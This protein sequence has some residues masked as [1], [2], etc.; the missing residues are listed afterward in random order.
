MAM[1]VS[2]VKRGLVLLGFLLCSCG[3]KQPNS[4]L[5]EPMDWLNN[6]Q[7]LPGADSALVLDPA[8][9]PDT[10]SVQKPVWSTYWYPASQNGTARKPAQWELSP[11]E[12]YDAAVGDSSKKATNWEM[13]QSARFKNV[14]WAGHCNGVAAA[15]TMVDEP[16]KEVWYNN[17]KFT[18]DDV[19]ALMV[20]AF[21]AGGQVIGGRCNLSTMRLDSNGRPIDKECRDTN[22]ASL[23]IALTNYLGRFRKPLI[24]DMDA[25]YPVWNYV[26]TSYQVKMKQN[27]TARDVNWWLSGQDITTYSINPLATSFVYYQME[28]VYNNGSNKIYEYILE[29]SD[30]VNSQTT[31]TTIIGGE[32]FRK[33]LTD[34]PDFLWRHTGPRVENPY[35]NLDVIYNIYNKSI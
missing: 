34:H 19:K 33:A 14:Q 25:N 18:P 30:A 31:G 10:G 5:K 27:L 22:P 15:G 35:L 13:Q 2:M 26:I 11:V 28:V 24:A 12:K 7:N 1:G 17:V 4:Q 20:E 29:L 9:L 8:V 3:D 32:W 16:K 23:H 6:P 21:Q